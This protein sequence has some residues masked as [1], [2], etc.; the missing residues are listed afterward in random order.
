M[1][2]ISSNDAAAQLA[3]G[4]AIIL[5]VREEPELLEA[6]VE[7]VLHIPMGEIP[8]RLAELNPTDNIIV[9]CKLG[10]RS[11]M[12]CDFLTSQGFSNVANLV[13]G[14]YAWAEEVDPNVIKH[15]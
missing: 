14:I 2:E 15:G 3:E 5:D 10:G 9:M 6:A 7:G 12:V 4:S 13:G 8:E 1:R 11:A